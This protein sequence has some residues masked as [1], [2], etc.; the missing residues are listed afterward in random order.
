MCFLMHYN[1]YNLEKL[2][3]LLLLKPK[4]LYLLDMVKV[5]LPAKVACISHYDTEFNSKLIL[6]L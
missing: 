1:G 3:F 4:S 5:D 2:I 6:T